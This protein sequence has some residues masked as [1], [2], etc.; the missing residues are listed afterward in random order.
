M[1][2]LV[3]RIQ[4]FFSSEDGPTAVEYTVML[5]L[6]GIGILTVVSSIATSI[7]GSFSTVNSS[8]S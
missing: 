1:R 2:S 3:S 8:M 6:V 5:A 4:D 7:S